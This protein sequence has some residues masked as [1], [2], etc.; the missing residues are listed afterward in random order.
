MLTLTV[1]MRLGIGKLLDFNFESSQLLFKLPI[2]SFFIAQSA[3]ASLRFS[4]RILIDDLETSQLL[5]CLISK[6]TFTLKKRLH[7]VKL[8]SG[9]CDLSI[10][11]GDLS[12]LIS[13]LLI[14]TEDQMVL[15]SHLVLHTVD[16]DD[17]LLML[18]AF[19]FA[20]TGNLCPLL[21]GLRHFCCE[22]L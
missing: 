21:P 13:D 22:A 12:L 6:V 1:Q 19:F 14:L 16:L 5:P 20:L 7:A 11:S 15:L 3:H 9:S 18:P 2:E 4:L 8:F 10:D 17:K